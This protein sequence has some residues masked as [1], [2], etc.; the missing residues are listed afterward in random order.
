VAVPHG[1]FKKLMMNWG[2]IREMSAGGI[3]FGAHTLHHPILTRIPLDQVY[4]EVQGSKS[5]IEQELGKPVQG[6]AYPNGQAPDFNGSVRSNVADAGIRAAF[7]LINGPSSLREVRRDPY[8]IRRIFI[9]HRHSL[10][11]YALRLSPV[12]RYRSG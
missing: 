1:F 9:S 12:N 2:Q 7:T 10:S 6:F 4:A 11:E 5:R 8:A 3:E